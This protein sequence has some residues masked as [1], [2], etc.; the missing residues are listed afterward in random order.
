M[1]LAYDNI[2]CVN[3]NGGKA[4]EE[5]EEKVKAQLEVLGCIIMMNM[6]CVCV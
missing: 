6:E 1:L 2:N 3:N 4:R 5:I